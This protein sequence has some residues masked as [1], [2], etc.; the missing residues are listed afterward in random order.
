MP[1][2][3]PPQLATLR[4]MPPAGAGWIHEIKFD[5][6]RAQAH[7]SADG[8]RVFTRSGLDWTKRFPTIAAELAG[9]GIDQA[10]IDGEI[11]VIVDSRT[12]FSALQADLSAGRHDRMLFYAFDLM[13]LDG[14]D[15][16]KV[17]LRERK[18]LLQKLIERT[19]LGPS[20]IYSEHMDDGATMFAGAERL[21]WEGIVSKRADAPYRSGERS[22]SWQKIKTSKR[23]TFHIVGFVPAMGG[24]AALHVARREGE[25]LT[26]VGKVGTGFTMKVSTDL[27]RRLDALPAPKQ[28]LVAKRHIKAVEPRLV[29]KVEY[30]DITADGYLRHPSF[31]GL[32][33]D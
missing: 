30:R 9:A 17:P 31:K 16:R 27:R 29:A 11:V 18:R 22:D 14:H 33:E 20:I 13:H 25:K 26:Y 28:K 15:L 21:N 2:F 4:P 12:D 24:I 5:G 3:I 6:Y 8:T 10:V 32:A 1:R 7:I 19:G 23:E